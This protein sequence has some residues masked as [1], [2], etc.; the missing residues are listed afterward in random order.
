LTKEEKSQEAFAAYQEFRSQTKAA[1]K[2]GISRSTFKKR[3]DFY[4]S[5][6][7]ESVLHRNCVETR[8]PIDDVAYAWIKTEDVSMFVRRQN[9]MPY[10]E[11]RDALIQEMQDHAP[12]YYPVK[13]DKEEFEVDW[14]T[15]SK[16]F[17]D[18]GYDLNGHLLVVD[19]ADIHIGKL[20]KIYETGA[21]YNMQTA[22]DR[23]KEG[24]E[25]ICYKAE[26]FNVSNIVF[27]IG[28]D[29]L[30]I[31]SPHRKTTA[32]TPQDTD[33]QW[34]QMFLEA[35]KCYVAAI[36]RLAELAPVHVVFCPSNHD[37]VSGWMLAD[38]IYSWFSKH[39]EVSF[40]TDQRSISI[41]HRKYVEFGSNLIGF[42]HG[43]GAKEK[44]L[45]H[46]MQ[47]EAREAWG[48]TQF[49]Y[50]YVHHTHHKNL[51]SQGKTPI[52]RIEKDLIG[53]TTLKT[54]LKTD[55][56]N[57]YI[58]TIRTHRQQMV[59]TIATVM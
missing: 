11:I 3:L 58:E 46:L 10:E 47:Y 20:S 17:N 27:V 29:I 38:T 41:A 4:H 2:L 49:A 32:G 57:V 54:G 43:D 55:T 12:E 45:S 24:I 30:H 25:E 19:P 59:G 18:E 34:W 33:G 36:E 53:L 26:H 23:V 9:A 8:T 48:R 5:D 1:K 15:H 7:V 16:S 37:F 21:E 35:K 22:V 28:N 40:G 13:L 6:P 50:W 14:E 42:T 51:V 44:D 39:P 52:Q 31:D 56:N